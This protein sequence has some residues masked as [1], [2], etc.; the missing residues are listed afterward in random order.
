METRTGDRPGVNSR[1]LRRVLVSTGTL[2]LLFATWSAW[3]APDADPRGAKTLS[4]APEAEPAP[5]SRADRSNGTEAPPNEA[6]DPVVAFRV[7]VVDSEGAPI[8]SASVVA[9]ALAPHELLWDVPAEPPCVVANG[10]VIRAATDASGWARLGGCPSGSWRLSA[11]APG[12]V[13][14]QV[15]AAWVAGDAPTEVELVL[16]PAVGLDVV[17]RHR[18]GRPAA[19]VLIVAGQRSRRPWTQQWTETTD[20]DGRCRVDGLA[21]GFVRVAC[22]ARESGTAR[23]VRVP[24]VAR[25]TLRAPPTD[26]AIGART[27]TLSVRVLEG[28]GV[29]VR[30]A[31]VVFLHRFAEAPTAT[32]TTGDDGVCTVTAIAQALACVD[33][34]EVRHAG[35]TTARIT[36]S[37]TQTAAGD[38]RRFDDVVLGPEARLRGRVAGAEG[39]VAGAQ[40]TVWVTGPG[41]FGEM[42]PVRVT[43]GDD[44]AYEVGGLPPGPAVVEARARGWHTDGADP[45]G[46]ITTFRP[47]SDALDDVPEAARA[48]LVAGRVVEHDVRVVRVGPA[49]LL[50]ATFAGVVLDPDGA[51]VPWA[52]VR[53]G[54]STDGW[55]VRDAGRTVATADGTF[56]LTAEAGEGFVLNAE[57][58]GLWNLEGVSVPMD[59]PGTREG[60]TIV[61]DRLPVVRGTVRSAL[62]LP[63]AGGEVRVGTLH[64]HKFNDATHWDDAPPGYVAADGTFALPVQTQVFEADDHDTRLDGMV[65]LVD[66]EGHA[67]YISAPFLAEDLEQGRSFDVGVD[68]GTAIR[69]RVV[70]GFTGAPMSD[71]PVFLAA[72]RG[73]N[74]E[75]WPPRLPPLPSLSVAARTGGN[76]EFEIARLFSGPYVVTVA[77]PGYAVESID[78]TPPAHDI[79]VR[80]RRLL[81]LNGVVLSHDASPLA[82][83]H[84]RLH[85]DRS[86]V[87]DPSW[88]TRS[89]SD[90]SFAFE[91]VPAGAWL[92]DV[93]PDAR[94]P[95]VQPTTETV[96]AGALGVRVHT[97][98]GLA[99]QGRLVDADGVPL[100]R[101]ALSVSR[102]DRGL[103]SR[104]DTW[105]DES[106]CFVF[107]GRHPGPHTVRLDGRGVAFHGIEVP[108]DVTLR[109]PG[110]HVLTGRVRDRAG[111]DRHPGVAVSARRV[112]V[113][114]GQPVDVHEAER[115]GDRFAFSGLSKGSYALDVSGSVAWPRARFEWRV[116]EPM[117]VDA[118]ATDVDLVVELVQVSGD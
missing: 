99:L 13:V 17:V 52:H 109:L 57:A 42:V 93:E 78:V 32:G 66:V 68:A 103:G 7:H 45:T 102:E 49:T 11:G 114:D 86:G 110:T 28:T 107:R 69:G 23:V 105:T 96:V 1:S 98:P 15:R 75:D 61:L 31:E 37:L 50:R 89:G 51:P 48:T 24:D 27:A 116:A 59:E 33:G 95:D 67:P 91:D 35:H 9:D 19:G 90:G 30:D 18:D 47:R 112:D 25:V 65:L 108:A 40:V 4:A 29:P 43:S 84:L 36:F 10:K 5:A 81:P 46:E 39:P 62:G 111:K 70:D 6:R 77:E 55:W 38:A 53:V 101:I 54:G 63:V 115:I 74:D 8:P 104:D 44:G 22:A 41:T 87:R 56:R 2:I 100:P 71:R 82:D 20:A 73:W 12:H 94:G 118:D 60:I 92:L 21:P 88:T 16:R 72:R 83:A 106:G 76:G 117:V 14:S 80:L 79:E 97:L 85:G 26:A 34:L 3:P 64:A 58:P 113:P